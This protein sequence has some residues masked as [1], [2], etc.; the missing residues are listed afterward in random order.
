[1]TTLQGN[2]PVVGVDLGGTKTAAALVWPEGRTGALSTIATPAA[3]GPDRILDAVADLVTSV[4][5]ATMISSVGVGSAGLIDAA[6]G[7][8]VSS[9]DAIPG[10]PGTPIADGLTGRLERSWRRRVPTV[11]END[12]DAHALGE[13]WLGAGRGAASLLL[14]TAGT[15]IGAGIVVGGRLLRGAHHG[16]GEIGHLP[17]PGAEGLRCACGRTGHLEAIAA[18]PAVARR[19]AVLTGIQ[20]DAQEVAARA[21]A[22]D[23]VA[24]RVLTDAATALGRGL[25]GLVT[26][27]D[28]AVVALGGG[29][30]GAG[31]LWWSAVETALRADLIDV[32]QTVQLV[33]PQLGAYAAILGAARRALGETAGE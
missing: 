5:G 32:L 10:W 31:E 8:V 23:D 25:A 11:V 16:A 33:R 26:T 12:V 28:P 9:T 7:V 18:G 15:G 22:G 17:A 13:A 6:R 14:V 27:L 29:L 30:A 24:V 4:A 2:A 19:F 3:D 21:E 1:M 20:A